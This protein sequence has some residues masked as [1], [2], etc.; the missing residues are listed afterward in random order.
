MLRLV[1]YQFE[2]NIHTEN[3]WTE[4]LTSSALPSWEKER[5][6][7]INPDLGYGPPSL[8]AVADMSSLKIN[9]QRILGTDLL[10]DVLK[11]SS[12][13]VASCFYF[14]RASQQWTESGG[15]IRCPGKFLPT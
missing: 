14:Q 7:R 11:T 13:L 1:E 8:D 6:V 5:F 3:M 9:I 12:R 10:Q 2:V 4:F 15:V